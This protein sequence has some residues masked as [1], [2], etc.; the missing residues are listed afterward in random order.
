ML[1]QMAIASQASKDEATLKRQ[2]ERERVRKAA[3]ASRQ[4]LDATLD[5]QELY[6]T[7]V[8]LGD[9]GQLLEAAWHFLVTLFLSWRYHDYEL[10]QPVAARCAYP[11]GRRR[12]ARRRCDA[13]GLDYA[14]CHDC[15][16]HRGGR[17]DGLQPALQSRIR[18]RRVRGR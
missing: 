3:E 4:P 6:A 12:R 13:T 14:A 15:C 11:P 8:R 10:L 16:E 2:A 5:P 7:A 17:A 9:A 1:A 18:A